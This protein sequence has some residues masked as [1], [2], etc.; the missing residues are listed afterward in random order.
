MSKTITKY[1]NLQILNPTL[2]KDWHPTKNENLT[3]RDVTAGSQKKV[4]WQCS[5]GHKW[6]ATVYERNR[7]S[8]CPY[9]IGQKVNDDNCLQTINPTLAK[10]WHSKK[11]N[12]LTPKNVTAGSNKKVWWQCSKGH[13]WEAKVYDRNR[14]NG[15]PYCIGKK[16]NYDNCLQIINPNLA[17]EWHPT[18]NGSLTPKDVTAFSNKKIWWH[19]SR[20]HEWETTVYHRNKGSDCPYCHSQTSLLEL[21]VFTEMKF[22]FHDAEHRKKINGVE[23]DVF[24]PSLNLAIEIDGAYYHK[25]KYEQDKKKNNILKKANVDLI[26]IREKELS[27]VS[28]H[29][30]LLKTKKIEFSLFHN[31]IKQIILLRTVDYK[32][33]KR[34]QDYLTKAEFVNNQEFIRIWNML[35]SPFPELSLN[36]LNPRLAKEWH[37]TKNGNLKPIDVTEFSGKKVWWQCLKGHEW[38]STVNNRSSG[39][40]CPYCSGR[41]VND[42]NCLQTINPNLAKEW[43]PTKNEN[44]T[45]RDITAG[46]QKKVWWQCLKG[47]EWESAVSGRSNGQGCPYCSGNKVNDDNCLQTINPNLAKE[48]HPT[49]NGSLTPKQI[50]AGSNKKVWWQCSKGHEWESTVYKRNNKCGCPYCG[51]KRTSNENC[52]QTVNPNLAKEWHP[53]KNGILTPRDVTAGSHKKVWWQCSKGHEWEATVNNRNNGSNCSYCIGKKASDENCLQNIDPSL[54]KEWHFTKNGSLTP[55]DVTVG[56]NKKVWWQCSRGHEWD[57]RIADRNNGHGCPVCHSQKRYAKR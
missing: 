5:K 36:T 33:R 39:F 38:E 25:N 8:G 29:D 2:A 41:K 45:P 49:K 51:G 11:N 10:E 1:N 13:E 23:C 48:W 42:D 21:R 34:I 57:A 15:C 46:S 43:H 32:V 22:L 26:R 19:C 4:W 18:K 47:H 9:C 16:V 37:S 54:A 40:N 56:S 52:L 53:N 55:K 35:P 28:S 44:L 30:I 31:L 20:G 14:G 12:R 24:L 17:K 50:T 3:P 27:K 7:G 6:E